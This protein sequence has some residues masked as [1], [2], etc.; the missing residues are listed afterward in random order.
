GR[1][2]L[3]Q[4]RR[5]DE[6]KLNISGGASIT[7]SGFLGTPQSLGI[8]DGGRLWVSTGDGVFYLERNRF[9]RIPG[10]PGNM[11]SIAGDGHGKIWLLHY[12]A[13]V[14]CWSPND[15]AQHIP[16]SEF[17]Q[18][19]SRTILPDR[20]Q[21]GVWLGFFDSGLVYLKDGKI[22]GSYGA[23]EGLGG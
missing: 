6:R 1:G 16:G 3:G 17:A 15:G 9:V 22:V 19:V 20:E 23:A 11:S 18:K 4:N 14:F 13:G 2:A 10:I 5:A 21:G 8:A 12:K 7:N